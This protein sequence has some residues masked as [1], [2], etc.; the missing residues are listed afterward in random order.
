MTQSEGDQR[1]PGIIPLAV[2]DAF[3]IIQENGSATHIMNPNKWKLGSPYS[4]KP[5]QWF[6]FWT[7]DKLSVVL[8]L[9]TLGLAM[10]I[11]LCYES[12]LVHIQQGVACLI[13]APTLR[14]LAVS[15]L[16]HLIEKD[17]DSVIVEHVEDSLFVMLDEETDSEYVKQNYLSFSF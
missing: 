14:H 16:R 2:K 10:D 9:A 3:S 15:T 8:V 11:L 17:P 7:A 12:G 4:T 6:W 1:S 13:N 5:E